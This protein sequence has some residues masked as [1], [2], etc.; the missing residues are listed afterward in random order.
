[1]CCALSTKLRFDLDKLAKGMKVK[2]GPDWQSGN[3]DGGANNRGIVESV[4]PDGVYG[5]QGVMVRWPNGTRNVY[6][7]GFDRCYDVVRYA[8]TAANLW[9]LSTL[10]YMLAVGTLCTLHA[11]GHVLSLFFRSWNRAIS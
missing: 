10:R 4:S 3:E 11:C 2:R 5:D 1:M 8:R 7:F 9:N 6:R